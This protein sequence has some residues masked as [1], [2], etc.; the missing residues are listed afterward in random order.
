M[1]IS[2]AEEAVATS[3]ADAEA[4]AAGGCGRRPEEIG[5]RF[6]LLL[7]KNQ[8]QGVATLHHPFCDL[9]DRR[10]QLHFALEF[11]ARKQWLSSVQF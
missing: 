6:Q 9:D 7:Q 5:S 3:S 2:E 10:E 8:M 4:V 11:P 1:V